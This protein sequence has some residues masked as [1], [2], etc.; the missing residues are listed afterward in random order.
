M[1]YYFLNFVCC[2]KVQVAYKD[3]YNIANYNTLKIGGQNIA[4]GKLE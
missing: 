3:A 1:Y 4:K 2:F